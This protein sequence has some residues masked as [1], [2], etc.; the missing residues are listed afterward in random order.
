MTDCVSCGQ[1]LKD[2]ARFCPHC[3]TPVAE[4]DEQTGVLTAGESGVCSSCDSPL[5]GDARFCGVCGT[6]VA[7]APA[8]VTLQA[9]VSP[10][11]D[12]VAE[13]AET[14]GMT[15]ASPVLQPAPAFQPA[16]SLQPAPAVVAPAAPTPSM[17]EPYQRPPLVSDTTSAGE[18]LAFRKLMTPAA[19]QVAFW[20]AEL[21][22]LV[23]WIAF[24]ANGGSSMLFIGNGG[25]S[26]WVV[27]VGILGFLTLAVVIRICLEL[28][29]VV[30]H[31]KGGSDTGAGSSNA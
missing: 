28:A 23:Y 16:P 20:L 10:P 8:S 9:S 1:P 12:V 15:T 7:D 21:F 3:G 14:R 29:V 18:Y 5:S 4:N 30:F 13:S 19:V 26:G 27:V 31:L 24:I 17:P 2:T 22:N 6:A 11:A 25:T